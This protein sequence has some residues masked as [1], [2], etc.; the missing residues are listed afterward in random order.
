ML[1]DI[2][3]KIIGA[4]QA[5]LP[6]CPAPYA[7]IAGQLGLTETEV[8]TRMAAMQRRNASRAPALSPS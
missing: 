8:M 5:G 3:R 7:V 6:L 2:D 1:D 4:T